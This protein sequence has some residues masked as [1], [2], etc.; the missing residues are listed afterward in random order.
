MLFQVNMGAPLYH[1]TCQVGPRFGKAGLL[2]DCNQCHSVMFDADIH[3]RPLHTSILHIYKVFDSLVCFLKGIWVHP[4]RY[5]GQ[6][7][8]RFG[9]SGSHV[10]YT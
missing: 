6:V 3:L 4:Y 5:T 10:E 2:V 1:S 9:K 8:T 7:G